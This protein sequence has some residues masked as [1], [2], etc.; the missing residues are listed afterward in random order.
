MLIQA[1]AGL[2]AGG[3][4]ALLAPAQLAHQAPSRGELPVGPHLGLQVVGGQVVSAKALQIAAVGGADG[5]E[6]AVHG[7]ARPGQRRVPLQARAHLAI[8][9][10]L[11]PEGGAVGARTHGRVFEPIVRVL[12]VHTHLLA[13]RIAAPA[14]AV[15]QAQLLGFTAGVALVDVD[16]LV[17]RGAAIAHHA[18]GVAAHPVFGHDVGDFKCQI[19][20][21]QVGAVFHPAALKADIG[22]QRIAPRGA[23]VAVAVKTVAADAYAPVP[24]LADQAEGPLQGLATKTA[25]FSPHHAWFIRTGE[26]LKIQLPAQGGG[27]GREGVRTPAGA[28]QGGVARLQRADDKR[29]I[30]LVQRQAILQQHDTAIDRVA[31]DARATNRQARLVGGTK[32]VSQHDAGLV[33]QRIA[34]GGQAGRLLRLDEVGAARQLLQALALALGRRG[35]GQAAILVSTHRHI[36]QHGSGL[37][38]HPGGRGN[39]GDGSGPGQGPQGAADAGEMGHGKRW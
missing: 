19:R 6:R 11:R 1:L 10:P 39:A 38:P 24:L 27:A 31:L 18:L 30:G 3:I 4:A 25:H 36:G 32:K 34:Q 20:P 2:A 28:D 7:A 5:V 21:R 29:A 8:G 13:Q 35:Q 23:V 22:V 16:G 9:P 15:G 14:R 12:P 33:I 37:G 26:R 17:L